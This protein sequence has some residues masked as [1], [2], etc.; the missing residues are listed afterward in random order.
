MDKCLF[1][2]DRALKIDQKGKWEE[3]RWVKKG[4]LIRMYCMRKETIFNKRG[5]KKEKSGRIKKIDQRNNT[6]QMF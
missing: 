2:S 5:K 6:T 1:A 4:K 3:L